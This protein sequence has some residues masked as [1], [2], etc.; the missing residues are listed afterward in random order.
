MPKSHPIEVYFLPTVQTHV[1]KV[2]FFCP[3]EQTVIETHLITDP[4][5][6]RWV[7]L[8]A[9]GTDRHFLFC[10]QPSLNHGQLTK[11]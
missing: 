9:T 11:V 8:M 7:V 1:T 10:P 3:C 5:R 6:L 4:E 2:L